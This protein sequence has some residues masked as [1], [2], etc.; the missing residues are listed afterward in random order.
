MIDGVNQIVN[1]KM[2]DR[3]LSKVNDK[4]QDT[5]EDFAQVMIKQML[6]IALKQDETNELFSTGYGGKVY[7][8]MMVDEYSKLLA[9]PGNFGLTEMIHAELVKL[10]EVKRD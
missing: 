7:H 2:D 4:L 10:Q 1:I 8:D 3:K 6:D 9:E 5:A